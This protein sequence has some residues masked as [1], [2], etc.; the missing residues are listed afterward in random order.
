M[1]VIRGEI[2]LDR[3]LVMRHRGFD[4]SLDV[5]QNAEVLF[6]PRQQLRGF[7]APRER[8]EK[9]R[10]RVLQLAGPQIQPAQRVERFGGEKVTPLFAGDGVAAIAQLPCRGRFVAVMRSEE[11]R[12]G[13]ECRS[14]W[15]PY[16]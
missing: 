5:G 15:S 2:P 12:V 7:A 3:A 1:L 6:D 4:L 14:R 11:R 10:A 9:M 13:K 8:L 16:H